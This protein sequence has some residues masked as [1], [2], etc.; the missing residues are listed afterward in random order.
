MEHIKFVLHFAL[1][2]ILEASKI[3]KDQVSF[4]EWYKSCTTFSKKTSIYMYR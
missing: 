3:K 2:V 1:V 4:K